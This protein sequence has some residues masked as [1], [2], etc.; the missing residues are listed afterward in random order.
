MVD[1]ETQ[2]LDGW[3]VGSRNTD[4]SHDHEERQSCALQK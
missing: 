2:T 4:E 1:D 3:Y